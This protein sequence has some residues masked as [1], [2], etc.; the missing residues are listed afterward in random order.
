MST[1]RYQDVRS[2]AYFFMLL[3][4]NELATC[5]G[6]HTLNFCDLRQFPLD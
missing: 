6:M 4:K 5:W 2:H 3:C 1:L